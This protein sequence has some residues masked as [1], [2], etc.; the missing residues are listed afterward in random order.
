MYKTESFRK[1]RKEKK[2]M[3]NNKTRAEKYKIGSVKLE[4]QAFSLRG[5]S[6]KVAKLNITKRRSR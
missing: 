4:Q 5:L 1:K 3:C 2:Y 6:T